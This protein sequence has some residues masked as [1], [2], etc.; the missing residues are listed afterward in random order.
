MVSQTLTH[1]PLR[2]TLTRV[3][4]LND[5]LKVQLGT[6]GGDDWFSPAAFLQDETVLETLWTRLATEAKTT[7]RVYLKQSAFGAYIWQLTVC[8]VASYLIARRVPDLSATNTMLHLDDKGWIDAMALLTPRFACLPGDPATD[9]AYAT[10]VPDDETL[11]RFYLQALLTEHVEAFMGAMKSRY[12]YGLRAMQETLADRI[13]G[14][15]IWLLKDLERKAEIHAEVEAFL[16]LLPFTS[17]SGVLEVPFEGGSEPFL[18]RASCCMSYRLPQHG[19]CTSCPLQPEE[20]R[21][22]RFQAYLAEAAH[23]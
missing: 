7:D 22:A 19:Y 8:G 10:V 6:P 4:S 15:L 2:E 11:R 16:A 5:H 18:K 21:I 17:K 1:T 12:K 23:G 13:A 9:D 3:A 20:E 14:S